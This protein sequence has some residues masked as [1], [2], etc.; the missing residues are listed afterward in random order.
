MFEEGKKSEKEPK[1]K[2][3]KPEMVYRPKAITVIEKAPIILHEEGGP[4]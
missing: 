1:K 3:K 4:S 2:K